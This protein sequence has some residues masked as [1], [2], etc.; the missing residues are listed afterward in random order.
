MHSYI[1][2]F[3]LYISLTAQLY[4]QEICFE[5]DFSKNSDYQWEVGD[6]WRI[7]EYPE[8]ET[9]TVLELKTDKKGEYFLN[10]KNH[11]FQ[12]DRFSFRFK[13]FYLQK[14]GFSV[15]IGCKDKERSVFFTINKW[16]L[17][18]MSK[19]PQGSIRR[20]GLTLLGKIPQ[21]QWLNISIE[22]S[23]AFW[24]VK[25][26][27]DD[28]DV[29]A[30]A[31]YFE[32]VPTFSNVGIWLQNP[33]GQCHVIVDDIMIEKIQP[34]NSTISTE[35][36]KTFIDDEEKKAVFDFSNGCVTLINK[37]NN[38]VWQ[39]HPFGE[40]PQIIESFIEQGK[41][42]ISCQTPCGK[43]QME[44]SDGGPKEIV[45]KVNPID[46][47]KNVNLY[48]P[49]PFVP[50]S[51]KTG[52][53][54]PTDEGLCLPLNTRKLNLVGHYEYQQHGFSMPWYGFTD[55]QGQGLMVL[56]ESYDDIS[57]DVIYYKINGEAAVLPRFYWRFSKSGLRYPR[58]M[59]YVLFDWDG[60]VG[61]CKRYK[62]FK[63]AEGKFFTLEEKSREVPNVKK[64]IGAADI[65]DFSQDDTV[66]DWLI[67]HGIDRAMYTPKCARVYDMVW[68]PSPDRVEKAKK[69]GYIVNRFDNYTDIVG[70]ELLEAWGGAEDLVLDYRQFIEGFPE[71]CIVDKNGNLQ[72]GWGF[73]IDDGRILYSYTRCSTQQ[74][75]HL[76]KYLPRQI[77]KYGFTGRFVDVL[78][79]KPLYE[80]YSK[81]HPN[82][83][84]GDRERRTELFKYMCSQGMVC[85]S[86]GG[87]DWAA[88]EMHYQEGSLNLTNF[89]MPRRVYVDTTPYR[90]TEE[91]IASQFDMSIRLPLRELVYHD[92]MFLTWRWNHTPNRWEQRELWDDWDLLH[93][94]Y[95]AMPIYTFD[96]D[97]IDSFGERFLQSYRNVCGFASKVDG[98]EMISH[99]YVTKDRQ[100]QETVFKNGWHALVNFSRE[101]KK[102]DDGSI[103][104]S[105][106]FL[107]FQK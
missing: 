14:E 58:V 35:L 92:S 78:T 11:G 45:V 74:L 48:Y 85:G 3:S 66:L 27:N 99:R 21:Q 93:I 88:H 107:V 61:M 89:N 105:K 80:C 36:C 29:H 34:Y 18:F 106:S 94:L 28:Y 51:A 95:A 4:S 90:L 96:E 13:T 86:E 67:K 10:S 16:G 57:M 73:P 47:A 69:Q 7:I 103:L 91:Y 102:L 72:S 31:T 59:R 54:F 64:L 87:A 79:A 38:E 22:R 98:T 15:N 30:Q 9:N 12:D 83:R 8:D 1:F 100:V 23:G 32:D 40:K 84:T 101:S 68:R 70:D 46:Q 55:E 39:Q 53:V 50:N 42:I 97:C 37:K 49:F 52:F 63:M 62:K 6:G 20:L 43:V 60:Y 19:Q 33:D 44:I 81:T 25:L 65:Y 2:L 5:K 76:Q 17:M 77:E 104:E 56:A 75:K 24:T 26:D 41:L 82:T 71:E